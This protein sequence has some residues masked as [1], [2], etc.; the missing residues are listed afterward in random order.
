MIKV[1][2]RTSNSSANRSHTRSFHSDILLEKEERGKISNPAQYHLAVSVDW[3]SFCN[4]KYFSTT[5]SNIE[6]YLSFILR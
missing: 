1:S 6:K 3:G 5:K 4:H 2:M